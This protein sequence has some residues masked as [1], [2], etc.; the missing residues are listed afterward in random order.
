MNGLL[1]RIGVDQEYGCWNAP[2]EI[3]SRRFV[4]V[5]IPDGRTKKYRRGCR[6]DYRPVAKALR[7]FAAQVNGRGEASLSLPVSLAERCSHLDPDFEYLTYGDNGARRGFAIKQMGQ[8]DI[9]A[10]Y[11]GLRSI[12]GHERLI[13]ALVGLYVIRKV[14]PARLVPAKHF[15]RNAHTRWSAIS[16]NDLVV[17]AEPGLSGRLEQCIPIG[18][19]R[20]RAYR[21]RQDILVAWGGLTVKDGYIQRSVRPP[22]F[23]NAQKFY[24]WFRAQQASLVARNN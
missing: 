15:D 18:E 11:A 9:L 14:M 12:G 21:V 2:V 24:K 19:W 23:Q 16:D 7:A 13:Y 5:P 3:G 20:A 4:Y 1:I 17:L 6:R 8:G 10:F 22:A